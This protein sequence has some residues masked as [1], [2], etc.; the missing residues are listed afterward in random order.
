LKVALDR[1]RSAASPRTWS[2]FEPRV[3]RQRPA[4]AIA[5]ELGPL[6]I[7]DFVKDPRDLRSIGKQFDSR[8]KE[9]GDAPLIG[10]PCK[11]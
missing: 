7:T 5:D 2:S 9:L 6:N 4:S 3:L 10:L 8:E 1:V 11:A